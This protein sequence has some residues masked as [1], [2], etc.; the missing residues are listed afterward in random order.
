MREY[1]KKFWIKQVLHGEYTRRIPLLSETAKRLRAEGALDEEKYKRL[2]KHVDFNNGLYA[3]LWLGLMALFSTGP[4]WAFFTLP[5][6][7]SLQIFSA[8]HYGLKIDDLP[9]Y[10]YAYGERVPARIKGVSEDK[11]RKT[12]IEYSFIDESIKAEPRAYFG[13]HYFSIGEINCSKFVAGDMVTV[14]YSKDLH[15]S[16]IIHPEFDFL[17]LR[18]EPS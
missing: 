14:A 15:A 10:L 12:Y 9:V 3:A 13:S 17:N 5:L 11:A 8:Y 1:L 4:W 6:F 18:K 2:R 16:Y 7:V